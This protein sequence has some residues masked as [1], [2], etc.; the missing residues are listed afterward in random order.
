METFNH[1]NTA[2]PLPKLKPYT[3][4]NSQGISHSLINIHIY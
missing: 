2:P 1:A 3:F 4:I